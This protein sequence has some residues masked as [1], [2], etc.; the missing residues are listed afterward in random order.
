LITRTILREEYRSLS[1]S[2]CSFLHSP[3]A[4]WSCYALLN[5]ST[6]YL[7]TVIM[8]PRPHFYYLNKHAHPQAHA[9]ARMCSTHRLLAIHLIFEVTPCS[10]CIT[11]AMS[12]IPVTQN[13]R[14]YA[15]FSK[16]APLQPSDKL[17]QNYPLNNK[18]LSVVQSSKIPRF[19]S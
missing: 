11:V 2:Y 18:A 1:S 4:C 19:F 7:M 6:T 8:K 17:L 9:L 10:S 16:E 5:S 12:A 15:Q 14:H 3:V 13:L